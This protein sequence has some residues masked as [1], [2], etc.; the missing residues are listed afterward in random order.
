MGQRGVVA[1]FI[2]VR[3]CFLFSALSLLLAIFILV[4]ILNPRVQ[5]VS[6]RVVCSKFVRPSRI[7][8]HFS[9]ILRHSICLVGLFM[10]LRPDFPMRHFGFNYLK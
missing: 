4:A 9:Q 10:D 8:F 6:S 7:V 2:F 5:L 3:F 1:N